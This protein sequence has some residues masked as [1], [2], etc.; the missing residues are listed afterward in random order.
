LKFGVF[1]LS[2]HPFGVD[3]S[4]KYEELV[5]QVHLAKKYGFSIWLGEH[6]SIGDNW[7]QPLVTLA[8][9]ASHA[10]MLTIG[11]GILILPIHNPVQVAEE[12]AMLDVLSKGRMVLGVG[13][14]ARQEEHELFRVPYKQRA[15]IMEEEIPLIRR[16]WTEDRVT[17]HG[18]YFHLQNAMVNPKPVQKNLPIWIGANGDASER[19]IDRIARL[20]DAWLAV[21]SAPRSLYREK[22]TYYR[23]ALKK[24]GK[25]SLSCE[26]PLLRE[27]YV[28]ED[29]ATARR[30]IEPFLMKKYKQ[31]YSW[32]NPNL[33][34]AF[35]RE[36]DMTFESLLEETIIVGS[37][38]ECITQIEKYEKEL[39]VT[40]M[41]FRIQ[42][43][44]FSHEKT[45]MAM[46]TLGEKVIP[47]F[48]GKEGKTTTPSKTT[49]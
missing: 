46:K 39:G 36:E 26:F 10:K 42:H 47:H 35:K 32:G 27:L 20:G 19:V 5:E 49:F 4:C 45:I 43:Q 30:D 21:Q 16:L 14:G 29:P 6:H 48:T 11:T 1:L 23:R 12:V 41:I 13:I 7:F 9:L 8:A 40:Q 31:Y 24:Y 33:R 2:Q 22:F 44:G 37:P 34:A 15:A 17:H 38:D 25:D 28:A 3:C 18:R